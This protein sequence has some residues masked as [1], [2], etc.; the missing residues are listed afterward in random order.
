MEQ[1]GGEDEEP[2]LQLPRCLQAALLRIGVYNVTMSVIWLLA[3]L[4]N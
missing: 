1:V 2:R 3:R 4:D